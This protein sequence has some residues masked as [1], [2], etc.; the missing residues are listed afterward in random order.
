VPHLLYLVTTNAVKQSA[1]PTSRF[2]LFGLFVMLLALVAQLGWNARVPNVQR[3][4]LAA[5]LGNAG[6]ICHSSGGAG[7][8]KS[9][10]MPGQDCPMCL[11]CI[12]TVQAA[13]LPVPIVSL[14]LPL[15]IPPARFAV[16]P[17]ATGPPPLRF[18][19]ARPRGPPA[20]A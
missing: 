1:M 6:A 4:D 10:A 12:S 20:Q 17:P 18:A 19:I 13:V 14:P 7:G 9:P 11:C 15:A 16:T 2:R 8:Q 3:M 5:L